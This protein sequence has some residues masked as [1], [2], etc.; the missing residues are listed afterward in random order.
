MYVPN[1]R[2]SKYVKEKL[3]ELKEKRG[4]STIIV[5]HFNTMPDSQHAENQEEHSW[6]EH[7]DGPTVSN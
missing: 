4:E 5:G 6:T 2:V 1:I 7:H 3:I